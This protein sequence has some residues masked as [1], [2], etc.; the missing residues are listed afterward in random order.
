MGLA[1]V[2]VGTGALSAQDRPL[3]PGTNPAERVV[4]PTGN[5]DTALQQKDQLE[6]YYWSS[7]NTGG[8]DPYVAHDELVKAGYVAEEQAASAQGGAIRGA[9]GGA[10]VGLA[11]GAIAGDAGKGAAIGAVSGGVV[12]GMRSRRGQQQAQST[13]DVA[14]GQF[15]TEF[16]K[17]DRNWTACM[18]GRD[19]TIT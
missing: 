17:W 7:D 9:A 2:I 10:L 16:Q 5:Q 14:I 13:A 4:Y 15:N 1:C 6:C 8:W 19:Y 18:T 3:P 12:G 11:I